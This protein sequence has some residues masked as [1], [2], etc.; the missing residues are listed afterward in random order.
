MHIDS[1][2]A[3]VPNSSLSGHLRLLRTG[4]AWVGYYL[5]NG[6][7]VEVGSG[8]GLTGP[9][10]FALQVWSHDYAFTDQPVRVAFDNFKVNK[11]LYAR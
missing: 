5:L 4:D 9:T 3:I 6:Q 10:H 7:W 11:G 2:I 8:P 1:H